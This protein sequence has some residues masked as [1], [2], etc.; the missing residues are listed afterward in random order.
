M[1]RPLSAVDAFAFAEHRAPRR[2]RCGAAHHPLPGDRFFALIEIRALTY[3]AEY[4]FAVTCREDGCRARIGEHERGS[5]RSADDFVRAVMPRKPA[6][7]NFVPRTQPRGRLA[8]ER[9]AGRLRA[10][11]R[12]DAANDRFIQHRHDVFL[13]YAGRAR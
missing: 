12:E 10:R 11:L 4:A 8:H 1:Q 2:P 7:R 9:E 6:G 5:T 3:G 13:Q